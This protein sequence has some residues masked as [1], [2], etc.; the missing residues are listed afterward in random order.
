L[1]NIVLKITSTF[2][3]FTNQNASVESISMKL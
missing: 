2:S 1:P 3:S